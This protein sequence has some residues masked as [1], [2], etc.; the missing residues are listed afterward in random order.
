M[1][2][3]GVCECGC[4]Q[5]TYVAP[6]TYSRRGWFKGQ[7]KRFVNGHNWRGKHRSEAER[8]TVSRNKTGERNHN[9]KGDGLGYQSLH[10][11]LIR[12]FPKTGV[13]EWCSRVVG[14]SGT[15][16]TH[17]ANI[18]GEYRRDRSD[19]MELCSSCHKLYDLRGIS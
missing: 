10:S 4:G 7:P 19:F 6:R 13:C 2:E 16:G 1:A 18:S 9:W 11:W 17:F 14:G 15:A 3:F 5:Q 8:A 12:H